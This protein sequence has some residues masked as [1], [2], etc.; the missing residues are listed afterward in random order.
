MSKTAKLRCLLSKTKPSIQFE[1]RRKKPTT[2]KEF[3]EHAKEFEDLYQLANIDT[4]DTNHSHS[5]SSTLTPSLM[6]N[7]MDFAFKKYQPEYRRTIND[8]HFTN[9]IRNN[10]RTSHTFIPSNS[11]SQ[12]RRL[13]VHTSTSLTSPRPHQNYIQR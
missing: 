2:T 1:V 5:V 9:H 8:N 11:S 13:P 7:F 4:N 6:N 12:Q 10:F 3:L